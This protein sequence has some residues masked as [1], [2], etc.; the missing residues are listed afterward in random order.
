LEEIAMVGEVTRI[1]FVGGGPLNGHSWV[2]VSGD[3]GAG[4]IHEDA[5]SV[6]PTEAQESIDSYDLEREGDRQVFRY[7][8]RKGA[9]RRY[10]D[11]AIG[12]P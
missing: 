2:Q 5:V 11:R 8:R 10:A 9:E 12:S 6:I 3:G 7:D 1:E 4:F